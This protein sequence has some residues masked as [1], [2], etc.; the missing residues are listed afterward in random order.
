MKKY[1]AVK[2]GNK[3]GIFETWS[4]CQESIKGF[5]G[6][7]YKSFSSYEEAQAFLAGIDLNDD[8]I[9]T[10]QKE[11]FCTIYCDGSY[12]K[13][14]NVE[15]YSGAYILIT[16]DGK[17]SSQNFVGKKKEFLAYRNVSGELLAALQAIE[18]AIS[19][20][21]D[22]IR[23][24]YDY[25]GIEK[26]AKGEWKANNELSRFYVSHMEDLQKVLTI[27]FIKV[28]GHTNNSLNEQ[29][30]QLAKDALA[31]NK[32]HKKMGVNFI[33]ISNVSSEQ[34]KTLL[35]FVNDVDTIK[36]SR[37][38][39]TKEKIQD[40]VRDL[41]GAKVNVQ[42]FATKKA[43]L[44]QGD[45]KKF[46]FQLLLTYINELFEEVKIEKLLNQSYQI[47]IDMS[48]IEPVEKILPNLPKDYPNGIIKLLKQSLINL[49]KH[50]EA[51][52]YSMYSFPALR[53]LEG[54]I[55]YM[56]TKN[57]Y[58]LNSPNL[59]CFDSKGISFKFKYKDDLNLK[60]IY[61]WDKIEICYGVFYNS[62][63]PYFHYGSL[64]G[65]SDDTKIMSNFD[66]CEEM[67]R[68]VFAIILESL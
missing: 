12:K 66:E 63:H 53:A 15:N 24:Y 32:V 67:I 64:I 40:E 8:I 62:R 58:Q 5:S 33:Y 6:H 14:E 20:E 47:K 10:N 28:A 55:K 42:Y 65:S 30:D 45:S 7:I 68:K 23:L 61:K 11:G 31:G 51:E 41:K 19:F 4:E 13:D 29:V 57:G 27:E 46:V 60:E 35:E 49:K 21:Q 22:K 56:L 44:I 54:H 43:I 37:K 25:E 17:E 26:W 59:N 48:E 38:V 16:A 3:T 36:T 2:K 52:D 39:N 9:E 18:N 34:Y 1:Y 50:F